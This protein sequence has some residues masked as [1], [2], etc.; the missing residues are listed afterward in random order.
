MKKD[1]IHLLMVPFTGLGLHGGYRGD[2]WFRHRIKIFKEYTLKSLLNQTNR[3][4]IIWL[5]F[6]PEEKDNPICQKFARYMLRIDQPCIFTFGGIP[7]WDDKYKNDNLLERLKV[8]LPEL[9]SAIKKKEY[10]YETCQ[11]SDD[12][13]HRKEVEEIQEH[14]PAKRKTLIH[15][16]GFVLN[17]ETQRVAEWN[18]TTIN[19]PFYT[20]MY[21]YDIFFDPQ[22]HFDYMRG[23]KS[24]EDVI[25]LFDCVKLPDYRYCVMV[26]ERNI[27]TNWWHP[28]RGRIYS[29]PEGREI[30][31]NFGIDIEEMP[32][33]VEK[34][35]GI[36]A[37]VRHRLKYLIGK[38]LLITG[39]Y[40]PIKYI[41][42]KIER[43]LSDPNRF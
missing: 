18:P 42:N 28:F 5:C 8:I 3:D 21:P 25:R 27:S 36:K 20:I 41:K 19:P 22:K 23:S 13:Y 16:K 31:K 12:F 40:E 4:F 9:E 30:L 33:I 43:Y 26:H 24:H 34:Y 39:L 2:D 32:V 14:K 7:I 10:I 1:F 15:F 37:T 11:P 17:K 35:Q 6:R 29:R 38:F